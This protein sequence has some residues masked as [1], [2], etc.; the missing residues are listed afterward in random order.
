[1]GRYPLVKGIEMAEMKVGDPVR[2][3]QSREWTTIDTIYGDVF[4]V[5]RFPYS[6][7]TSWSPYRMEDKSEVVEWWFDNP[8][9]IPEESARPI[10]ETATGAVREDKT[11]KGDQM[12]VMCGFPRVLTDLALHMENP[13]GRNWEKGLPVSGFFNA[14]ERHKME[15]ISG[16]GGPSAFISW[17][18]NVLCMYETVHRIDNGTLPEELD[19]MDRT[20]YSVIEYNGGD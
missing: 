5:T 7:S 16:N 12:A 9:G 11:G 2:V 4:W 6:K 19:D 18:W 13:H 17:V 8:D 14:A 10:V 1:M 3:G 20:K 15:Y